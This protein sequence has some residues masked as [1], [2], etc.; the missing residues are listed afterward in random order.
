MESDTGD[1][2]S[3][4]WLPGTTVT[5]KGVFG[6]W[7]G[8]RSRLTRRLGHLALGRQDRSTAPGV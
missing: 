8:R 6:Y 1:K 4:E 2:Q 3:I 5:G 7:E